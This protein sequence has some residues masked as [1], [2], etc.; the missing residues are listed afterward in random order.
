MNSDIQIEKYGR[1]KEE[2]LIVPYIYNYFS[3]RS[4]LRPIPWQFSDERTRGQ[5]VSY[6]AY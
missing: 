2:L 5:S 3:A 4:L 6:T 1:T